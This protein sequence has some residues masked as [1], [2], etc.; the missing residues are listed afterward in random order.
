MAASK[1]ENKK[2]QMKRIKANDPVAFCQMG[3]ELY[4]EGDYNKAVE[5]YTKA[6]ELGDAVAHYNLGIM[7]WN[8]EGVERDEE[9]GVYHYEK[10]AMGGHPRARHNL[11]C[12]ECNTGNIERSVKHLIIAANLGYEESMKALWKHYSKGNITKEDLDATLR[13]HHA[14]INE[15]KSPEREEAEAWRERQRGA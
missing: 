9:K 8:G 14:A 3:T 12:I 4:H 13:T 1:E 11:G 15:M 6:A 7:Y 10:A 5:Y 2:R